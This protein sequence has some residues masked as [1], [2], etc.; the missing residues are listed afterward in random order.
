MIIIQFKDDE[1]FFP[2]DDEGNII[3]DMNSDFIQVWQVR[4]LIHYGLVTPYGDIDLTAPSHYLNHW[5]LAS[6]VQWHSFAGNFTRG[7]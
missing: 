2:Y 7:T 6:M 4:F 3:L 1:T 5:W